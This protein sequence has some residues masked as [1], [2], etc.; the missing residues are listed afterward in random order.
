V[1]K[2][3]EILKIGLGYEPE[4][5]CNKCKIKKEKEAEPK[6]K[7]LAKRLSE[8]EEFVKCKNESERELYVEERYPD[9]FKDQFIRQG[10]VFQLARALI[11]IKKRKN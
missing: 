11:S 3:L 1:E 10:A 2:D 6:I 8:D 7:E 9:S 4:K 5:Y